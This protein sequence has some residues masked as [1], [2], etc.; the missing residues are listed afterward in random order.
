MLKIPRT[1]KSGAGTALYANSITL[2]PGTVTV[3]GNDDHLVIHALTEEAA[4]SLRSGRMEA[5]IRRV[6][7]D[8]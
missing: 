1:T 8:R 3:A 4:E 2:T 5:R 7:T 6:E